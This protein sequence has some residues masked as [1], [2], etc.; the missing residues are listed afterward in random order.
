[1]PKIFNIKNHHQSV[2]EQMEELLHLVHD[3]NLRLTLAFGIGLHH[4]G[5]VERDRTLV[6]KLFA[7]QKIQTLIATSTL[8]WGVNLPAHLVIV[9]GTEYFDGKHGRYCDFP[10]TGELLIR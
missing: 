1:M 6:E 8:A 9:K 10:I 3:S 7:E 2:S 4:A 5:L